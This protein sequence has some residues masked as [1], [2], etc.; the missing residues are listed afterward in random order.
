MEHSEK[1]KKNFFS[2]VLLTGIGV[3]ALLAGLAWSNLAHAA[4]GGA[5]DKKTPKIVY[6]TKTELDFEGAQIEGELRNPGE[7]FFQH[8]H[9]EKFDSLVKPRTQFHREMLRDAMLSK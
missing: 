9:E 1:V 3:I 6:P 7:F 8:R 2:A 5:K 4:G